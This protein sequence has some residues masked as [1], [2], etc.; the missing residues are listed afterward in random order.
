MV[1]DC[2]AAVCLLLLLGLAAGPA[3]AGQQAAGAT[4]VGSVTIDGAVTPEVKNVV[5]WLEGIPAARIP[6]SRWQMV[7]HRARIDQKNLTFVP[8]VLPVLVG[9]TV[10]FP[11]DDN[12]FHNVFSDSAAHKFDL[13]LYPRGHSRSTKF[14][15]PGIVTVRCNTHN[16]MRAYVV[17]L[18]SPY[19]T[20]PNDRG[21]FKLTDIPLGTYTIKLWHPHLP[22]VTDSIT[23]ER[24]GEVLNLDFD[25]HRSP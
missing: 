21:I 20:V 9:T 6:K 25:L 11:N 4:L 2:R 1:R 23:A 24:A 17:V 3:A 5:V 16:S 10:D 22:L 13:G 8:H 12:V 15:R 14:D 7:R 19:F 18:E